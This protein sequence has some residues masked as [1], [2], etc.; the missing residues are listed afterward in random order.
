MVNYHS[1]LLIHILTV[2]HMVY[3]KRTCAFTVVGN[4]HQCW[5]LQCMEA[6]EEGIP[7][8]WMSFKH[9]FYRGI[10]TLIFFLMILRALGSY[11]VKKSLPAL[12]NVL[13]SGK[14][15]SREMI[16]I[17]IAYV[18]TYMNLIFQLFMGRIVLILENTWLLV[19]HVLD[20]SYACLHGR[21]LCWIPVSHHCHLSC[22]ADVPGSSAPLLPN[23]AVC[24]SSRAWKTGSRH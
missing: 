20:W 15:C 5:M 7:S 21:A 13:V 10:V 11:S 19:S 24:E 2:L 3:W 16:T 18:Y 17:M 6:S 8:A 4:V 9:V 14:S 23:A 1:L 22:P 12:Q